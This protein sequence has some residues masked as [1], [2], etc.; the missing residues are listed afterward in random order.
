MNYFQTIDDENY[1]FEQAE[2]ELTNDQI[3]VV[4]KEGNS[5]DYDKLSREDQEILL[6]ELLLQTALR[7]IAEKNVV[8]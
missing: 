7:H 2:K 3:R 5:I 8:I 4:D 1:G 6:T